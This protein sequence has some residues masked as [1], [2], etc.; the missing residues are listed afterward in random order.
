MDNGVAAENHDLDWGRTPLLMVLF[1][2]EQVR[3]LKPLLTDMA[4]RNHFADCAMCQDDESSG[5][6]FQ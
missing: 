5:V 2:G 6:G 4:D 1:G 3:E